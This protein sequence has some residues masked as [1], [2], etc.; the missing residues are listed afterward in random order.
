MSTP[1]SPPSP[2]DAAAM[3]GADLQKQQDNKVIK[4]SINSCGTN[5]TDLL[6]RIHLFLPK[7]AAA[8]QGRCS[9]MFL[10]RHVIYYTVV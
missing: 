4:P 8:N 1:S 9:F 7:I 6:N 2:S 10:L 3:T 5:S